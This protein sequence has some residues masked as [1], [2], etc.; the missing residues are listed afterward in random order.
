MTDANTSAA[1]HGLLRNFFFASVSSA[2]GVLLL[3]LLILAGR[4]LGDADFGKFSFVLALTVIAEALM[5]FGLKDVTTRAVARDRRLARLLLGHT[6]ALKL[7]WAAVTMTLLVMA[8]RLLRSEADVRLA[9]YLLA[10]AAVLRSYMTT[11]RSVFSGL[12]RFDL[13][14]SVMLTDRILL[15]GCGALALSGGYGLLGLAAAFVVARVVALAVTWLLARREVGQFGLLFDVRTWCDLQARALPFAAFFIVLNAY[16]YIDTVMLGVMRGDVETGWYNAAYRI[17][18]GFSHIPSI[19]GFA[20]TPRLARY[21]VTDR[22]RHHR[23][24]R[25]GVTGSVAAGV[26]ATAP[27]ILLAPELI[28][29]C[30]GDQ[31]LPAAGVLRVLV[32]GFVVVFPLAVLHAVAISINAERSL[33][34]TATIGCLA[35]VLLNLALIPAYGMLGASVA[36]VAGEAISLGVL[37]TLIAR[38]RGVTEAETGRE[39]TLLLPR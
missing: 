3:V 36:T 9:G 13:E 27:G 21:F 10:F 4:A 2:S 26:A 12:E 17:Y 23:L 8:L 19:I 6:F 7:L 25:I 35:N 16:N 31:Y 1:P 34:V 37:V 32:A 15:L 29:L 39:E 22:R 5:D 24:A 33:L 20:I 14:T 38:R 28:Y 30:F 18:E 11:V